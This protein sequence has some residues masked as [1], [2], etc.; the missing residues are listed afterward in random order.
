MDRNTTIAKSNKHFVLAEMYSLTLKITHQVI[1]GEYFVFWTTEQPDSQ[2]MYRA[3]F[4]IT[5]KHTII[6]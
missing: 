1:Q 6:S 4:I 3:S 2:Y 5:N